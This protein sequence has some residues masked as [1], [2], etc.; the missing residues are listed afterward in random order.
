MTTY[1]VQLQV[2]KPNGKVHLMTVKHEAD[3]AVDAYKWAHGV[4]V[5]TGNI[6]G[7][8]VTGDTDFGLYRTGTGE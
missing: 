3:S 6:I 5:G 8:Y 1:Q 4:F 2:Q 7:A